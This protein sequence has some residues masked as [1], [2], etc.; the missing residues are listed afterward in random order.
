ELSYH[1]YG[2][3]SVSGKQAI[4]TRAAQ[5]GIQTAQLEAGGSTIQDLW[6]DLRYANVSAW[7]QYTIAYCSHLGSLA[8]YQ[9]YIFDQNVAN[10]NLRISANAR[11]MPQ[12]MHFVRPGAVRVGTSGTLDSLSFR[13]L[14]GMY[15]AI[16][17]AT[18]GQSISLGGLPA[19]TYGVT[20]T[21]SSAFLASLSD[22]SISS[23]SAL[24]INMPAAGYITVYQKSGTVTVP[25]PVVPPVTPPVVPPVTP[26]AP[27][28]SASFV[29]RNMTVSGVTYNYKVFV[30]ANYNALQK[31][32]AV[33]FLHGSGE[34]GSDN[35]LQTTVGLG[36]YIKNNL[37]TFPMIAVFPQFPLVAEGSVAAGSVVSLQDQLAM[38]ALNQ[39]LSEFSVDRNRVYL[40]GLSLGAY[41]DWDVAYANPNTFA[42]LVPLSG[43]I[44]PVGITGNPTS[45]KTTTV[46]L[47]AQ[48]LKSLPIW[49]F[50]GAA[51]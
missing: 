43:D 48:K 22:Q 45:D 18:Q 36:V 41:R 31:Y 29:N 20:Y 10:P 40:T 26:P 25:P 21:T 15:V 32:P 16:V 13:N 44:T 34:R 47:V 19:G 12:I 28:S 5:L 49:I 37:S 11:Y 17:H 14:N 7:Q 35:N 8:G 4:A 27:T 3:K 39:T 33:M 23:G 50:H 24:N 1:L 9:Y 46:T 6:D 30:P 51:D 2:D 42:A 38:T